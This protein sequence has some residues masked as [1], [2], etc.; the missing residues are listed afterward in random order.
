M[1]DVRPQIPEEN[2]KS[3]QEKTKSNIKAT[4]IAKDAITL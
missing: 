2:L 4:E 3:I 1:A